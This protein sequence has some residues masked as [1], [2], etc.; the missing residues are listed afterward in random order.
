MQLL[1]SHLSTFPSQTIVISSLNLR[2][3]P[4]LGALVDEFCIADAMLL[5]WSVLLLIAVIILGIN[6]ATAAVSVSVDTR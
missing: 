4:A 6:C 2:G 3:L 5:S 1:N